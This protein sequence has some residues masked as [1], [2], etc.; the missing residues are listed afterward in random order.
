MKDSDWMPPLAGAFRAMRNGLGRWSAEKGAAAVSEFP[1]A[2]LP[3]FV[4]LPLYPSDSFS[5]PGQ[6][7]PS[8]SHV[9]LL[10]SL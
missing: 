9:Q 4:H 5:A 7:A 6:T 2:L 3:C 8:P 1:A 10:L